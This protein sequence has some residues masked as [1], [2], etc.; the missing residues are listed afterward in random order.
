MPGIIPYGKIIQLEFCPQSDEDTKTNASVKI[1]NAE[2]YHGGEP[3]KHGPYD[4]HLGTSSHDYV[5]STC[6]NY[7]KDCQGH[8]GYLEL[9][10]PVFS[11]LFYKKL[12][13]WIRIICFKCGNIVVPQSEYM[14]F[15][16]SKRFDIVLS[17]TKMRERKCPTKGCEEVHPVI[18][19]DKNNSFIV[20]FDNETN[21][22]FP[23]IVAKIM[24][25]VSNATL[26]SLGVSLECHPRRYILSIIPIPSI[27]IRPDTKRMPGGKAANNNLTTI[28]QTLIRKNDK[29]PSPNLPAFTKEENDLVDEFQEIYSIFIRGNKGKHLVRGG[30]M[31][32]QSLGSLLKGKQGTHRK[33]QLGKRVRVVAR[34]TI[35]GDPTLRLHQVRIPFKFAKI[36]QVEEIVQP[37]NWERLNINYSNGRK[38]YPGCTKIIKKNGGEYSVE[39]L[40]TVDLELGDTLIRDIMTGDIVFYNRSPSLLPSSISG[41]EVVV[42]LNPSDL[43]FGMN[44][45]ICPLFNADFDGDQMSVFVPMSVGARNEAKELAGAHNFFIRQ[46]T[47]GPM[48]GQIDDSIIGL[49]ALTRSYVRMDKAHAALLFANTTFLPELTKDTYTGRDIV[50]IALE[51]T[52]INY[53]CKT[54]FYQENLAGLIDYDPDEIFVNI[55][56]GVMLSGVLD[57]ASIGKSA[58]GGLYHKI[59][60]EYG[61]I[62]TFNVIFNMQQ[63]AIAFLYQHGFTVTLSDMLIDDNRKKQI[64]NIESM[65]ISKSEIITRRLEKGEI[66]PPIGKTVKQH[67][68]D[69]QI[70]ELRD[71]GDFHTPLL[72]NADINSN[73]LLQLNMSGSKGSVAHYGH[74]AAG[75]GPIVINGNRPSQ[76]AAPGRTLAH[77]PRFDTSPQANGLIT[78]SYIEGMNMSEEFYNAQNGRYDMLTRALYTAVTGEA[79]RKAIKNLESIIVNNLHMSIRMTNVVQMLCGEDALDTRRIVYIRQPT[80]MISDA[81]FEAKFHYKAKTKSLQAAFDREFE[82]LKFDRDDYRRR[83][84]IFEK[85]NVNEFITDKNLF[86]CDIQLLVDDIQKRYAKQ[87]PD[88]KTILSMIDTVHKF[89]EN[90]P[91]I[92]LNQ[93]CERRRIPIPEHMKAATH[94]YE[95]YIRAVLSAQNALHKI[96]P[97]MLQSI[98]QKAKIK[99][100]KAL[101]DYGTAAGM[102]AAMAFSEPLTQHMLDAHH[103]ATTG[104]T[105]QGVMVRVDEIMGAK[106]MEKLDDP[107]MTLMIRDEYKSVDLHKLANNIESMSLD[108]FIDSIGI[109]FEEF[110][111]PVHPNTQHDAEWIA[112]F[113]R[114]NHLIE[115]PGNLIKWCIRFVLNRSKMIY[116]TMNMGIIINKLRE[117]Y[118][119]MYFVYTPENAPELIIRA[120]FRSTMFKDIITPSI[121]ET[122]RDN[123]REVIIRGM[124]NIKQANVSSVRRH[125]IDDTGALKIEEQ[126]CIKTIGTNMWGAFRLKPIETS[127]IQTTAISEIQKVLGIEAARAYLLTAIRNL[128][129][130]GLNRSHASIYADE[131]T[132]TGEL[133][134]IEKRGLN[135]RGKNNVLLK[136][137]FSSPMQTLEEAASNDTVDPL[138]GITPLFLIGSTPEIGTSYNKFHIDSEMLQKT[139]P[140]MESLSDL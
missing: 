23:H 59:N 90:I 42:S 94:N 110:G 138:Q 125:V 55:E 15:P 35:V 9:K 32:L 132:F 50:S 103:R 39:G 74:I 13:Q 97:E 75:I 87:S 118:H 72:E 33:N 76:S 6:F 30:S 34:T 79:N 26:Q 2:L 22:L 84:L 20:Y 19:T 38:G 11:P 77:F 16:V 47:S 14:R 66:I 17:R 58:V 119:D 41:M 36:L 25:R 8:S 108:I 53:K 88:E 4:P 107:Q 45:P 49:F 51:S 12:L 114:I 104:G 48:I 61:S 124:T 92:Y 131:M 130:G 52:P 140:K 5:C 109:Y 31:P 86:S 29:L 44:V 102:I 78:S 40:N 95:I 116:K 64:R 81:D 57:K 89:C 3:T 93:Q 43:T 67:Y 133:T 21:R 137:G 83:H 122:L 117:V 56:G 46:S 73:C 28:I 112:N 121:M 115:R 54:T 139:I 99:H 63:I 135:M 129:P 65:V 37:Y 128:G 98:L 62:R 136:M 60:N 111:N 68:E 85:N 69:L 106:P 96:S 71:V 70:N 91:Y 100:Y 80:I 127:L 134:S 123:M 10:Y 82:K 24:D 126:P 1:E 120:Y 101:I 105:S 18:R 27:V 7:K 113:T